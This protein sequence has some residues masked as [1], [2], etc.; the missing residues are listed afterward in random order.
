MGST[1]LS[2]TQSCVKKEGTATTKFITII[3]IYSV[4]PKHNNNNNNNTKEKNNNTFI[5][6]F[7][8]CSMHIILH[9]PKA[10]DVKTKQPPFFMYLHVF[11]K[12]KDIIIIN[13]YIT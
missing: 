6:S 1:P 5:H 8:P 3:I 13:H 4:N 11:S 2:R 7:F 12:T 10:T 9:D